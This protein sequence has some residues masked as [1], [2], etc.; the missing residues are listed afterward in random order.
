MKKSIA[1]LSIFL[2]LSSLSCRN[3]FDH[4]EDSN[5]PMQGSKKEKFFCKDSTGASQVDGEK[6]PPRK[7]LQQWRQTP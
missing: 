6:E 2:L 5:R 1:I 7:D 3:E 4:N